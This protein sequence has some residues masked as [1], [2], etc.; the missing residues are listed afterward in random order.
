M[1]KVEKIKFFLASPSDVARERRYVEEVIKEINDTVASSQGIVLEIVHSG[2]T[3][4]GF[5][6]DGQTVLN[7]QIGCMKE[8][9]LFVGIM[10]NRIGTKTARAASGTVEEFNR[11]VRSFKSNQQPQIWFY[12][13]KAD[14]KLDTKEQVEQQKQVIAFEKRVQ[15][16][17]LTTSYGKP[18]NFR[19]EFRKH[20]LRWLSKRTSK[21]SK[22]RAA[23]SSHSKRSSTKRT[24]SRPSNI[25]MSPKATS[26]KKSDSTSTAE[27]RSPAGSRSTN[28]TTKSISSSGAWVM[29]NDNFFL[30]ESVETQANQSAIL[31]MKPIE[32]EQE[33]ALRRLQPVQFQNKQIAY[34]YQNEAAMMR[35]ESVRS[36][37]IRGKTIFILILSPEQRSQGSSIME[38]S[39]NGYSA[40]QIAELRARR[41]LLNESLDIENTNNFSMI[42]SLVEGYAHEVKI[43]KSIFTD[44]WTRLKTQPPLFL[45][46]ARLVAVY[47]LKM[48]RTVEHI[49]ELKLALTKSNVMS[50]QFRGRRRSFSNNQEPAVIQFK[51]T[52]PLDR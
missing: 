12:F 25:L 22:S 2:K 45:A 19:D 48:S 40:D 51:G 41:L 7:K 32:P 14:T 47:H 24:N 52:C 18:S 3:Y 27:K 8:Y 30:T 46:H 15:R 28:R 35:V 39:V 11:A 5:G 9:E 13:R 26:H 37:S 29:L 50:V 4:P 23:N 38:R 34:A 16:N 36:K 1:P 20:I 17:A 31:H 44:L 10:W 49:L 21:T 6:Q 42:N 43:K 33:A